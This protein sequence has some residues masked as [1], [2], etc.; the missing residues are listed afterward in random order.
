MAGITVLLAE[1]NP[2]V[3]ALLQ[4]A[5]ATAAEVVTVSDGADALLRIAESKP[6]LVIADHTLPGLDGARLLEKLRGRG[7]TSDVAFILMATR[8]DLDQL[9]RQTRDLA[10][11]IV[12]KPFFVADAVARIRRVIAR[13]EM[14]RSVAGA[15]G[16]HS[17][18]LRGRLSQLS[19]VDLLQALELGGKTCRL[20]LQQSGRQCDIFVERGAVVHAV[21]GSLSGEEGLFAALTWPDGEFE[22][23]FS[24]APAPSRT[25]ERTTQA[26]LMDGLR[27]LD[28]TRHADA[29]AGDVLEDL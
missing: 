23:D 2:H 22:I 16:I 8:S 11:D 7:G 29:V 10:D 20:T 28:E 27:I 6:E 3:T 21:T 13:I 14:Q 25:I 4:E 12:E 9:P 17:M 18:N 26:L 1:D 24:G 15:N 19:L 5:L